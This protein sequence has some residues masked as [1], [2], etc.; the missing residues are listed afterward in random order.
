MFDHGGGYR[1]TR[2]WIMGVTTGNRLRPPGKRIADLRMGAY[3]PV[4]AGPSV[5]LN[6]APEVGDVELD[7]LRLV[8][9]NRGRLMTHRDLLR[10]SGEVGYGNDT[11]VLRAQA[12]ARWTS[13][14]PSA[15]VPGNRGCLRCPRVQPDY[16]AS[17]CVERMRVSGSHQATGLHNRG[18]ARPRTSAGPWLADPVGRQRWRPAMAVWVLGAR[19]PVSAVPRIQ[20]LTVANA[21]SPSGCRLVSCVARSRMFSISVRVAASAASSRTSAPAPASR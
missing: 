16:G 5:G 4:P 2:R 10:V 15:T 12:G 20:M 11:Q 1:T 17:D 14:P 3:I 21:I 9:R 8:A 7:L 13:S 18:R 19:I 6:F